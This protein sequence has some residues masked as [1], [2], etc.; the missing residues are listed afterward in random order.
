MND[1]FFRKEKG[2][3]RQEINDKIK[4]KRKRLEKKPK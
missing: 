1:E 4:E 2:D 3:K